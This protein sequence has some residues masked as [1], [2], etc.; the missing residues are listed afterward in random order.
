MGTEKHNNLNA[1]IY[2]N[3]I[4]NTLTI[5][6]PFTAQKANVSFVDVLGNEVMSTTASGSEISVKE[7]NLPAGIYLVKIVADGKTQMTKIIKQ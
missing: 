4:V 1:T 6:L 3:P 2:P 7:I 5:Q